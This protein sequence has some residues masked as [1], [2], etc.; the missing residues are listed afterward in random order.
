MWSTLGVRDLIRVPSPAARTTTA[1]G[2]TLV[3]HAPA[4]L[5]IAIDGGPAR[6]RPHRRRQ[7]SR[8]WLRRLRSS[9]ADT[10]GGNGTGLGE[11]GS[12]A[13]TRTWNTR[14]K[15]WCVADY[16]TAERQRP[17]ML[18]PP[19]RHGP[20]TAIAGGRAS[21]G[22]AS[23][24]TAAPRR[25]HPDGRTETAGGPS[26]AYGRVGYGGVAKRRN[27]PPNTSRTRETRDAHDA[28]DRRADHRADDDTRPDRG[29][30]GRSPAGLLAVRGGAEGEHADG[31]PEATVGEHCTG[32]LRRRAA[33]RGRG[34]GAGR[35]G[36]GCGVA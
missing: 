19:A 2:R 36:L 5:G 34:R 13:T 29:T 3:T 11:P 7:D 20:T 26:G 33:A 15:I 32:G 16:T 22:D 21:T 35:V 28:T 4:R 30:D 14:T 24:E 12:A 23:T 17:F 25:Q 27:E 8:F 6:G 18:A 9:R 10:A 1:T 31:R